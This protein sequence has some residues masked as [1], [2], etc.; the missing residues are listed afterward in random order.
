MKAAANNSQDE[1]MEKYNRLSAQSEVLRQRLSIS[2]NSPYDEANSPTLTPFTTPERAQSSY[3]QLH[4]SEQPYPL[5]TWSPYGTISPEETLY[6]INQQIKSTLTELLNCEGVKHDKS[7]RQWV[8]GRLMDAEME[9]RRQRRR[10]SSII[11]GETMRVFG[12]HSNWGSS[13]P[14]WRHD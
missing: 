6:E 2:L 12:E 1:I 3:S 14:G 7:Y 5:P 11:N 13:P 4:S 9:L 10:R 8:Q